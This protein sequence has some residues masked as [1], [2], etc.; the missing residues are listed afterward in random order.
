MCQYC[1]KIGS[2]DIDGKD[3]ELKPTAGFR[4]DRKYSSWILKGKADKKAN[5]MIL[6]NNTNGVYFSINYCPMCGRKLEEVIK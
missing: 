2:L 6:T 3:F 1:K 5:I 4:N